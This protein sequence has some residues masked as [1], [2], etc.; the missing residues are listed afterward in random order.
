[1]PR[2]LGD[3]GR[4]ELA[5]DEGLKVGFRGTGHRLPNIVGRVSEER[6][7]QLFGERTGAEVKGERLCALV[8]G[9]RETW[10][11]IA[12]EP[13]IYIEHL[14]LHAK[15]AAALDAIHASDLY[16]ACGVCQH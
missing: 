7:S 11:K 8:T 12:I 3:L 2:E 10:P 13:E 5:I 16:L 4:Q 6:F 1:M 9:S 14:A 15:N